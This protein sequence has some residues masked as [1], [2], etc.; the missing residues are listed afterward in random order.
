M[1]KDGEMI[2]DEVRGTGMLNLLLKFF[3]APDTHQEFE[4]VKLLSIEEV[5]KE[6]EELP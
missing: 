5:T 4:S 3:R 2:I 6:D 1:L